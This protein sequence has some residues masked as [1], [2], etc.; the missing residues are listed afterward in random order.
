MNIAHRKPDP[1][2]KKS[3]WEGMY[4]KQEPGAPIMPDLRANAA[5]PTRLGI[6]M[7]RR[8]RELDLTLNEV[9]ERSGC[10]K[11]YLSF[12]ENGRRANPPSHELLLRIQEALWLQNN[13]LVEAAR[14]QSTPD[15]VKQEYE[16]MA[17]RDAAARQLAKVI[18]ERGGAEGVLG[19]GPGTKGVTGID[20]LYQTGQLRRLIE[21]IDAEAT[22]EET[23]R[24]AA[25][26]A[27]ARGGLVAGSVAREIPLINSVAAGYPREF[28]DLGYPARVADEY[29]RTPEISDPD[30]FAA[31]VVGDSML[32]EYREGDVVV[33]SPLRVVKSGTDCF[34][35]I[36]PD[37]ETTFK[38]VYFEQGR[39]GESLIRLQPLNSAYPPRVLARE[40]VAG[41]YAAVSVTRSV[42]SR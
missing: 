38:R 3:P 7:N 29:V 8:R 34:A 16:R 41:L 24:D 2:P 15:E 14:W 27:A 9:A 6:L 40:Q 13:E 21:A 42:G 39:E 37:H 23:M 1:L 20:E 33:F 18:R 10:T 11:S 28:T 35:R 22:T 17:L 26:R 19:L 25:I 5:A 32:P 31:R 4:P 36:E 12:I 30:A